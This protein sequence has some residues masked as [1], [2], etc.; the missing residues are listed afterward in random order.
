MRL[1]IRQSLMLGA[2]WA[3]SS[4]TL[5]TIW[6]AVYAMVD[7]KEMALLYAG[8]FAVADLVKYLLWPTAREYFDAGRRA[9]AAALAV[10][11]TVLAVFS[12]L[13]TAER[14]TSDLE[15]RAALHQAHRQHLDAAQLSLS[16]ARQDL[17]RLDVESARANAAADALRGR[18]MATPA[19]NLA[20]ASDARIDKQRDEARAR[21]ENAASQL[22]ELQAQPLPVALPADLAPRL[23]LGLALVLEVLPALLLIVVRSQPKPAVTK[24]NAEPTPP[25]FAGMCRRV[26]AMTRRFRPSLSPTAPPQKS[27]Q[28]TGPA[29]DKRRRCV[30]RRTAPIPVIAT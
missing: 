6:L 3:L 18:G 14:F 29:P 13:A 30:S 11:A 23:G 2:A 27:P 19:L 4:V 24:E 9:G 21:L 26:V 17:A 8:A 10:A 15:K 7:D 25:P 28:A 1:P 22:A 12:G 16:L 5:V 20:T